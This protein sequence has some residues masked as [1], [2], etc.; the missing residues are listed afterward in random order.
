MLT[1]YITR[2]GETE[3]NTQ[4]RSQGW[5]N[6]DLTLKGERDAM[7]LGMHLLDIPFKAIYSST[8]ERTVHTAELIRKNREIPII[9]EENLREIHL[10]EWEGKTE[11]E[12]KKLYPSDFQAYWNTPSLYKPSKGECFSTLQ[13][14]VLKA[15]DRIKHE[16]GEGNILIVTHGVVVKTLVAFFKGLELDQLWEPPFIHGTSLTKVEL[17]ERE[18]RIIHIGE[19]KH[20]ENTKQ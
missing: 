7:A 12:I 18:H 10:G 11:D 8:S 15:I 17:D 20:L 16:Q 14:R 13:K 19:L 2:H 9:R 4:K 3:W 5:L 1:L 6:S